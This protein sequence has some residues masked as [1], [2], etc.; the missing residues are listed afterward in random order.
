MKQI[1]HRHFERLRYSSRFRKWLAQQATRLGITSKQVFDNLLKAQ[2][3]TMGQVSQLPPFTTTPVLPISITLSPKPL[4]LLAGATQALTATFNPA[5]SADKTVTWQSSAPLVATISQSGVVTVLAGAAAGAQATFTGTTVNG[6]TDTV[7]LTVA[8]TI[9]LPTSVTISPKPVTG[10]KVGDKIQLAASVLPANANNKSLVW[11]SLNPSI[12]TVDQTG[13]ATIIAA[14]SWSITATSV[15]VGSV[16]DTVTGTSVAVPLVR[17]LGQW[18]PM[19][20]GV[21]TAAAGLTTFYYPIKMI[22]GSGDANGLILNFPGWYT[23]NTNTG[24]ATD[25]GNDLNLTEVSV[26]TA[27]QSAPVKFSGVRTGVVPNGGNL[28]SD[29]LSPVDLGFTN[30]VIPVGTEVWV[31]LKGTIPSGGKIPSSP[32]NLYGQANVSGWIYDASVTTVPSVDLLPNSTTGYSGTKPVDAGNLYAPLLLGT[33]VNAGTKAFAAIGD[34][35]ASGYNDLSRGFL[36]GGF[37]QRALALFATPMASINFGISGAKS[38]SLLT[39]SRILAY[40][41]YVPDGLF[42]MTGTNDFGISTPP[43]AASIIANIDAI[44]ARYKGASGVKAGVKAVISRLLPRTTSTD[45]FATEA[46]QSINVNWNPGEVV[47]QFNQ[48]ITTSQFDAIITNDIVRGSNVSKWIANGTINWAVSD[49]THP[50]NGPAGAGYLAA[51][52]ANVLQSAWGETTL[53]VPVSGITASGSVVNGSVG[54]TG[55]ATAVISPSGSTNKTGVWASSNTSVV[56]INSS[57]GAYTFVGNGTYDITFTIGAKSGKFSGTVSAASVPV[58]AV[59]VTLATPSGAVGTTTQASAQLTPSNATV[60]TGVWS[61]SNQTIATINSAGLISRIAAGVADAI[62]TAT[63]GVSGK[64]TITVVAASS[65][66]VSANFV[67]FGG[68]WTNGVWMG[69]QDKAIVLIENT[70]TTQAAFVTGV[71]VTFSNGLQLAIE[72]VEVGSNYLKLGFNSTKLPQSVGAPNVLKAPAPAAGS[73]DPVYVTLTT[74]GTA[75]SIPLAGVNMSGLGSNPHV[76]NSIASMGTHYRDVEQKYIVKH[77]G[78]GCKIIRIII[79]P[80]RCVDVGGGAL[81]EAYMAQIQ[82]ALDRCAAAGIK[83]I[84]DNHSY[85]RLYTTVAANAANPNNYGVAQFPAADQPNPGPRKFWIPIGAP[86]CLMT[87]AQYGDLLTKEAARFGSHPGCWGI[88]IA[89]EPFSKGEDPFNVVTQFMADAQFYKDCITA[90]ST[91]CKIFVPGGEYQTAYNWP[92]ISDSLKNITDP[93]NQVIYEAHQYLDGN[94]SGGGYWANRNE[95]IP[96]GN[97]IKMVKPFVDWLIAN[98]KRGIIGEHG[99]PAGNRSA[100]LATAQG[101]DY[102]VSKGV[103]AL[104][105]C[106]GAGWSPSDVNAVDDDNLTYKDNLNPTQSAYKYSTNAYGSPGA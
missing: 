102:L 36:G 51:N 83:A 88:G 67:D 10:S 59:A 27:S 39:D 71:T 73:T 21:V 60:Q 26:Q 40:F 84:L 69:T 52:Y 72:S 48:L 13:L 56:T 77:S 4:S 104:Q 65:S 68:D 92:T 57:T 8:A 64:A 91:T 45:Q 12:V 5:N 16:V 63:N 22:T 47:D 44:V 55:Q 49:G 43:T 96:I 41:K 46:N 15:A 9:V 82:S 58:T 89:N 79:A 78:L 18:N 98:G 66:T 62:F 20:D 85:M 33:F 97:F 7:S 103:P 86:G 106:A 90:G 94:L 99:F 23:P 61:T 101:L 11:A 80:E 6:K 53:Y 50:N 2:G 74:P 70:A 28:I 38:P 75:G 76:D 14:G 24:M 1:N 17:A 32:R 95:S 42:V 37:F 87:K 3:L 30:G 54:A 19:N 81:R 105:W 35:I 25:L 31:K 100:A 34:S 29:T 93:Y